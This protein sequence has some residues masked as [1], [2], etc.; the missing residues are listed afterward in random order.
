MGDI[1]D[2]RAAIKQAE[3]LYGERGFQRRLG[4]G[5]KP[6]LL[7]IDLA[8]AWTN[9]EYRL[10]FDLSG[11]IEN[12]KDILMLFRERGLP[13][14][15]TGIAYDK[16]VDELGLLPIKT[17]AVVDAK[18][19]TPATEIDPRIKPLE[20]EIVIYKKVPS[21]F[22]GTN[23]SSILTFRG[24]DTIVVTGCV[25]STCVR[26]T[27]MDGFSYGFRPIVPLECVGDRAAGPHEWSLFDIDAKCGDVVSKAEV[28]KYLKTL[29]TVPDQ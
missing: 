3:K 21:A 12:T 22:F 28:I 7:I 4:F 16:S 25:T 20:N 18:L 29:E 19:G 10:G 26:A 23:L 6:A 17:P 13:V 24:I 14:V 8:V 15:F 11:V 27:V 9:P 2:L 5:K 1:T